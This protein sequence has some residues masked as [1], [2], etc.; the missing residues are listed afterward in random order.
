[1]GRS[2]AGGVFGLG[3]LWSF[4][5]QNCEVLLKVM[6]SQGHFWFRMQAFPTSIILRPISPLLPL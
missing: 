5:R 3:Y 6:Q 4:K 2:T 1:M